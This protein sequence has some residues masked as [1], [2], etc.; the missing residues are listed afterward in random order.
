M[1][2]FDKLNAACRQ[3]QVAVAEE[4]FG[5][6]AELRDHL[7]VLRESMPPTQQFLAHKLVQLDF[8]ALAEQ[9]EALQ[10]IGSI[11]ILSKCFTVHSITTGRQDLLE[12]ARIR[13]LQVKL[14]AWISSG[15]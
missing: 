5:L 6:A 1:H 10:A 12:I 3:L 15:K 14:G 11:P 9:E 4:N 2:A 7:K 13:N 8:G